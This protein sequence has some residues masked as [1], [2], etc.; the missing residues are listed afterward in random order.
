MAC[1]SCYAGCGFAEEVAALDDVRGR[2]V[3]AVV[4]VETK[5]GRESGNL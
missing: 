3:I 2:L 5:L 4:S 1:N